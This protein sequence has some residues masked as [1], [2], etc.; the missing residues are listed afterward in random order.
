MPHLDDRIF[1]NNDDYYESVGS[2]IWLMDNH[3]WSFVIWNQE[4]KDNQK[5]LLAHVDYHWDAVYDYWDNPDEE[6]AFLSAGD[7]EIIDIVKAENYIRFDSFICPAIAKGLIDEVH[8]YC[9]QGDEGGDIAIGEE[10]L[11]KYRCVQVLHDSS[12]ALSE[13]RTTKPILFDF[14]IDLFNRSNEHYGSDIW[15]DDEIE[16]LLENCKNLVKS[17]KIITISMSYGYSGTESD[18]KRLTKT[19]V[20]V[21][22]KWRKAS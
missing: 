15:S 22:S 7:N 1:D 12:Q 21:F 3:K 17:A 18:T 14:C 10:F 4:I 16:D 19:A 6:R 13:I 5:Y 11:T 2:G 9:H 8:F 20:E